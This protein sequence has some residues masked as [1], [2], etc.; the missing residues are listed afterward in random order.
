VRG[1]VALLFATLS[2][3]AAAQEQECP[4]VRVGETTYAELA[5]KLRAAGSAFRDIPRD[6]DLGTGRGI[7]VQG[8]P[9][10]PGFG[11]TAQGTVHYFAPGSMTLAVMIVNFRFTPDGHWAMEQLLDGR[12]DPAPD[13]PA[14]RIKP[15][16]LAPQITKTWT[17]EGL[18]VRLRRDAPDVP[19]LYTGVEYRRPDLVAEMERGA[20]GDPVGR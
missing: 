10:C 6:R 8:A 7:F 18:V 12:Y 4:G 11:R 20:A 1:V 15:D 16:V 2:L 13:A 3:A 19:P 14:D 17:R 5:A 9:L